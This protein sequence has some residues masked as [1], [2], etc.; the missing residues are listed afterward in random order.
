MGQ[1]IGFEDDGLL[2]PKVGPWAEQKYALIHNY[3]GMFSRAMKGKWDH[4]VYIDLFSGAG[5]ARFKDT[6][7]IVAG[8]PL[9]A[10]GIPDRFDKYIFCEKNKRCMEALKQR[11]LNHHPDADVSYVPNDVN[12]HVPDVLSV[13]P[14]S[15]RGNTVLAFCLADPF[16][17]GNLCFDTI[18]ELAERYVDFLVLIPTGMHATRWWSK[19]LE[20]DCGTVEA[21]TGVGEWRDRWAIAEKKGTT[22]DAF[23]TGIF[24]EQMHSLDYSY[25]GV[26][27]TV[28]FKIPVKNVRLY[29]LAFFSRHRLGEQF[30]RQARKYS[31]NQ[32]SLLDDLD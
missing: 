27:E 18:R 5:K 19:L 26:D 22:V 17:L 12:E 10:L 28:L 32:L 29:R 24:H 21:F 4:R 11:V 15:G 30:W 25:G 6:G 31:T 8:S 2:T 16:A 23:L 7:R 20:P 1:L 9:I 14:V 13:M 3:A